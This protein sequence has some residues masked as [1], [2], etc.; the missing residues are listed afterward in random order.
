MIN[1]YTTKGFTLTLARHKI[2]G[3]VADLP[4]EIIEHPELGEHLE[5]ATNDKPRVIPEPGSKPKN[6][7]DD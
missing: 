7:K 1:W 5:L 2:T 4:D 6:A 3:L